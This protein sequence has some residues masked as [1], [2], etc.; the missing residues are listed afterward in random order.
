M[1]GTE[2]EDQWRSFRTGRVQGS[3]EY[4]DA[5]SS[6][7]AVITS[8][9]RDGRGARYGVYVI[10]HR[11][12]SAVLYVG[13]AGTVTQEGKLKDQDLLGRLTNTRGRESSR[14]WFASLCAA[15]G[16][17]MVEY[18]LLDATPISPTTAEATLLQAF[19]NDTGRLQCGNKTL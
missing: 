5:S 6:L 7:R 14:T 16:P 1:A 2:F 19:L 17:L 10:R 9:F 4:S 15:N 12:T 8:H 18:V 11:E 3:F 13:K